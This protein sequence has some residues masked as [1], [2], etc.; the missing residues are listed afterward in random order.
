MNAGNINV[1]L[2]WV[3]LHTLSLALTVFTALL[4]AI[5]L[6]ILPILQHPK[7]EAGKFCRL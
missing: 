4:T 7:N 6:Q 1:K 3:I 5:S 2:P